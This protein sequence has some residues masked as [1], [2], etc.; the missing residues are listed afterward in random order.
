MIIS[1]K[2]FLFSNP[3]TALILAEELISFS[4]RKNYIKGNI[5]GL[6]FKGAANQIMS[7]YSAALFNYQKCLRAKGKSRRQSW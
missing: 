7:N 6:N 3:D 5:I 4:D 1:G 2:V